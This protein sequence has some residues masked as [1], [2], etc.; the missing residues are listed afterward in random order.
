MQ[1]Y[2]TDKYAFIYLFSFVMTCFRASAFDVSLAMPIHSSSQ[3]AARM[4]FLLD[5]R[6]H[7]P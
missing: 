2:A 3:I 5:G 1:Q 4:P 7:G 6:T